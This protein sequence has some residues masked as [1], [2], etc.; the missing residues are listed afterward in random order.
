MLIQTVFVNNFVCLQ[1]VFDICKQSYFFT[2]SIRLTYVEVMSIC[3]YVN[4]IIHI[5]GKVT[6]FHPPDEYTCNETKLVLV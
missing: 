2:S 1:I 5:V 6:F 4:G 3:N